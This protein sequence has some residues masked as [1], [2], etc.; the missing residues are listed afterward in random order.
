MAG[1]ESGHG[2]GGVAG[3]AVVQT[4]VESWER[5]AIEST[6][7]VV[8]VYWPG[9]WRILPASLRMV[10]LAQRLCDRLDTLAGGGY[11]PT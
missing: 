6:R 10:A 2:R 3:H 8:T 1:W 4:V 9:L 11:N 7:A 5:L